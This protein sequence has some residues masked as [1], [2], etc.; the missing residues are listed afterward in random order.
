MYRWY[1]L[2]FIIPYNETAKLK[3]TIIQCR[4]RKFSAPTILYPLKIKLHQ[5]LVLDMILPLSIE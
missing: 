5:R 4:G 3:P 2:L 1:G